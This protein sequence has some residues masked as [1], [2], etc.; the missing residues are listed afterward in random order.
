MRKAVP[1]ILTAVAVL[2][3]CTVVGYPAGAPSTPG[4]REAASGSERAAPARSD[5]GHAPDAQPTAEPKS[6]YGNPD[7]YEVFGVTYR[8]L[9]TSTGYEE[10]GKASWYG[11]E[12]HGRR[13]SSGEPYDMHAMTGA[14]RTLPLPTYVEVTNLENGRKAVV[15][16]NDRG[17]F[18]DDRILDVSYAAAVKLG[19][20]G[21]GTARV[22]VRALEPAAR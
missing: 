2:G 18:K 14:H 5:D 4:P 12:F 19:L 21:P 9:P 7:Q 15:R 22:R 16:I 20:V 1:A 8:V 13:T 6:A 3:G 11:E 10:E 17:P